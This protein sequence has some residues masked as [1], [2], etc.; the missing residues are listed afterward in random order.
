[1]ELTHKPTTALNLPAAEAGAAGRAHPWRGLYITGAVAALLQLATTLVVIAVVATLGMRPTSAE[2]YFTLLQADRLAAILRDDFTSL[3]LIGLY[4]GTFPAIYVALRPMSP[5][6]A[7][8]ATLFTFIGVTLG[9]ATHS[10][11][12]LLHLGDQYA[13]AS[14]AA[15]R[16]QLLAA[17]EAVL[18]NNMWNSSGGYLAGLLLQGSGVLVSLLMLRGGGFSKVTAIAGLLGNGFDLAQHILHPFAPGLSATLIQLAGPFYLV[19]FPMLARDLWRRREA[20]SGA[21]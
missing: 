20:P 13:A 18:A 3:A 6:G 19:W 2:E 9:F 16:S 10:G 15:Q 14:T 1:M 21:S 17:G 12:A 4:L 8:L 5:A 7:G 11:F